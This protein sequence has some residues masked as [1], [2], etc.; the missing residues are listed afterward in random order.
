MVAGLLALLPA[1]RYLTTHPARA[2]APAGAATR[3]AETPV[4]LELQS[5]RVPFH[6]EVSHLG[7]VIWSGDA[8][9]SGVSKE[10][11]MV[12]PKEGVDLIVEASWNDEQ[13]AVLK[14]SLA[15]GDEAAATRMLWGNHSVSDVLTFH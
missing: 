3:P 13:A 2:A 6:F 12:F 9:E 8:A 10:V 15:H 5:T 1:L 11:S 7:K 4:R 14:V